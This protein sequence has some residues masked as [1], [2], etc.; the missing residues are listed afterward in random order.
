MSYTAALS[1]VMDDVCVT[2]EAIIICND[3]CHILED[4]EIK[5]D[6]EMKDE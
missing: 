6:Q 5:E 1:Y 4:Q 2:D 3:W